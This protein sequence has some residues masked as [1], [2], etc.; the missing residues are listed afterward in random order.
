[1][2]LTA[3]LD[4]TPM[5][6][7]LACAKRGGRCQYL[8]SERYRSPMHTTQLIAPVEMLESAAFAP[9]RFERSRRV[10]LSRPCFPLGLFFWPM[11]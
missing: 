11:R 9:S 8:L 4:P 1:M 3:S 7:L 2:H 6:K 10:D 5:R